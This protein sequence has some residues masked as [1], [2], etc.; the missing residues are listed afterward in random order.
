MVRL[1]EVPSGRPLFALP[2]AVAADRFA[3]GARLPGRVSGNRLVLWRVASGPEYRSLTH[4]TAYEPGWNFRN[5]AVSPDGR[6]AAVALADGI[7]C[8]DLEG[9]T[10]R[11]FVP[12]GSTYALWFESAGCLLSSGDAGVRRWPV[13]ADAGGELRVG[14]PQRLPLGLSVEV[15]ASRDGG[16]LAAARFDEGGVVWHRDRPD[17]PDRLGPHADVRF[18][19]VSP[20]G[21]WVATG[22]QGAH[23][24]KVW[25]ARTGRLEK[26]L[27]VGPRAHLAFS[28]DG[29]WLATTGDGCQLWEVGSWR[30]GPRPGGSA[31]GPVAFS[32]DGRVLALE[33]GPG[34]LR[35]VDPETGAEYARLEDP[36]QD[37]ANWLGFTPDGSRLLSA[38]GDG[39]AVHVWDL[40]ALGRQLADRGLPWDLPAGR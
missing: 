24:V 8:W 34:V 37:R 32:A 26:E 9:G 19:A 7:G 21:A 11:T 28:P 13:R 39:Q 4:P 5:G 2:G 31:E 29:R 18:I 40:R 38:T 36:N 14:P 17:R 12:C 15:A 10:E 16:V 6:L 22:S 23:H 20:G 35:L 3:F 30:P 1:W 27:S 33:S 25:D